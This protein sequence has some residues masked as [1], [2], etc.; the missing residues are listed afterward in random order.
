MMPMSP[1]LRALQSLWGVSPEDV[2]YS[3]DELN[4]AHGA[5]V[6][7]ANQ[8]ARDSEATNLE[9]LGPSGQAV[10]QFDRMQQNQANAQETGMWG[11]YLDRLTALPFAAG[12]RGFDFKLGAPRRRG[13]E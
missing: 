8:R 12:N 10:N 2:P 5:Q 11:D 1:S 3:Q 7:D 13:G 9:A 4:A 6:D